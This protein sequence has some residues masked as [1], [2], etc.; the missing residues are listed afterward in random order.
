LAPVERRVTPRMCAGCGAPLDDRRPQTRTCS[1]RCRRRASRQGR[2]EEPY[3]I[4]AEDRAAIGRVNARLD[5]LPRE[6]RRP[7]L[8][9]DEVRAHVAATARST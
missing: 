5:L 4:T 6:L 3:E 7:P 9:P 8:T 2:V 1:D